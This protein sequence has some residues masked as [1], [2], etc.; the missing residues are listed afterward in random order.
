MTEVLVCGE[1]LYDVFIEEETPTGA[2][3]DARIGGSPFNVA[4]GLARMGRRSGL[5][6]GLSTDMMGARLDRAL[7]AEGVDRSRLVRKPELTTLAVVG[8]GPDGGARYAFYGQGAA[9]RALLEADLPVLDGGG[10]ALHFGSYTLVTEPT[11]SAYLALARR[12]KRRRLISL[13]PNLR[14][15]VEPDLDLWRARV[16][17]FAECAD[18]VKVSDEDL[19]LLHPGASDGAVAADWF[20]LGAVLVVITRGGE[21]ATIFTAD[22]ARIERPAVPTKVVDTVGAG[23]TF[24][25][26]LL[27]AHAEM[28]GATRNDVAARR[29]DDHQRAVDFAIRAAAITC[30]RRGADLP[31]RAELADP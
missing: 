2:R 28:G 18:I 3:L 16:R 11:A 7:A 31:R 12:E 4:V 25:A 29:N 17:A 24:Q 1:A 9:D 8:L 30:S 19:A 15:T 5:F 23:D 6:A 26:A 10:T 27:T 13:D 20:G 22:G 14:P 21:G